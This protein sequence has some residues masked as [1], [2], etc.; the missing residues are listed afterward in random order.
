[1]ERAIRFE[2][3]I[4][5]PARDLWSVLTDAEKIPTWWEGLHAV[6]LTDPVPGGIYTLHYESGKPDTCEILQSEPGKLLRFRWQSSE[7]EPTEVEYRLEEIEG[8]TRLHFRNSGY[9]LDQKWN[10]AFDANFSG[11]VSMLLGV[12]RLLEGAHRQ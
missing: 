6:K 1:M 8:G 12:R 2:L 3:D 7:P 10:K 11:W 5:A 9:G 4:A